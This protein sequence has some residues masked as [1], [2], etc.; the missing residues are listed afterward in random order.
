MKEIRG[1]MVWTSTT[2]TLRTGHRT[3]STEDPVPLQAKAPPTAGGTKCN[4]PA[5]QNGI[6][7][8]SSKSA[9][10]AE[11][12]RW[13]GGAKM[14][15]PSPELQESFYPAVTSP[16]MRISKVCPLPS[17]PSLSLCLP[18]SKGSALNKQNA[19]HSPLTQL[20]GRRQGLTGNGRS[21]PV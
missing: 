13:D 12:K 19:P 2:R 7:Q 9:Q 5:T 6:T 10:W 21:L 8:R 11:P 15:T 4:T 1:S 3:G 17:P 20:T 18:I 16:A 14:P